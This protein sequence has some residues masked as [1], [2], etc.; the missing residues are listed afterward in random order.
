MHRGWDPLDLV[1]QA[2]SGPMWVPG[3]KLRTSGALQQGKFQVTFG[4]W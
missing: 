1:L 2:V 4:N 3:I